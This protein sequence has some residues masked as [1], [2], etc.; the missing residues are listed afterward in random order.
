MNRKKL[1]NYTLHKFQLKLKK[2]FLAHPHIS[3]VQCNYIPVE[4]KKITQLRKTTAQLEGII[5]YDYL[6]HNFPENIASRKS[7]HC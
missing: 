3:H 7:T 5:K 6:L 4:K 2:N 1:E